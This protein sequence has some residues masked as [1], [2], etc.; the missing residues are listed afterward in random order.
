M[1]WRDIKKG[2]NASIM[3]AAKN[4]LMKKFW[5]WSVHDENGIDYD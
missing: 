5:E 2:T 1:V 3:E 4:N